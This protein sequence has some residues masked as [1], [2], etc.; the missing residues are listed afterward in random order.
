MKKTSLALLLA[1]GS[2]DKP[3]EQ[4]LQRPQD[5]RKWE[6]NYK[7]CSDVWDAKYRFRTKVNEAF[8]TCLSMF[9]DRDITCPD[10][11]EQNCHFKD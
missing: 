7:M 11:N 2:C 10:K 8:D 3:V 4:A 1:L 9:S 5:D 6:L